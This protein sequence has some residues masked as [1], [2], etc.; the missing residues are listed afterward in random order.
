[1][2]RTFQ[3]TKIK[4]K[5]RVHDE[6]APVDLPLDHDLDHVPDHGRHLHLQEL[7]IN[8]IFFSNI[9]FTY[10]ELHLKDFLYFLP[11]KP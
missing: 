3:Y 9:L 2:I 4:R 5:R 7:V 8:Q 6:L 10:K 1:M 11:L